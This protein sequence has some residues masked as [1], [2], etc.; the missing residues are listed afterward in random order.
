MKTDA[1][2]LLRVPPATF[3]I[4]VA[5]ADEDRHIAMTESRRLAQMLDLTRA[6]GLAPRKV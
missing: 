5:L 2:S 3:H 1:E 6:R 4:L